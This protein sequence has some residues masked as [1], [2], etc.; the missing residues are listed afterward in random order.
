MNAG[1]I[2]SSPFKGEAGRGMGL[3]TRYFVSRLPPALPIPSPPLEG[4]GV[5]IHAIAL[6]RRLGR[7]GLLYP[8]RIISFLADFSGSP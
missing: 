7:R 3:K 1:V 6:M 4:E 2:F 5:E 8:S